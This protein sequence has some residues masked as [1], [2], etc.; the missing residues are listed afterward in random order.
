M[1]EKHKVDLVEGIGPQYKMILNELG[2][3][4][5]E[6]LLYRDFLSLKKMVPKSMKGRLDHFVQ[7]AR[8]IQVTRSG[9]MAEALHSGRVKDLNN[10]RIEDPDGLKVII[11]SA[12]E[13]GLI[14]AEIDKKTALSWIR[15]ATQYYFTGAITGKAVDENGNGLSGATVTWE[16]ERALS[17]EDGSFWL[18]GIPY[19]RHRIY[20]QKEGFKSRTFGAEA[21]RE[22]NSI[23]KIVLEKGPSALQNGNE[24]NGDMLSFG[25]TD[26]LK[27]EEVKLSDLPEGAAVYYSHLYKDGDKKFHTVLRRKEGDFLIIQFV[28][29]K[30]DVIDEEDVIGTAY[31]VVKG[32]LNRSS[33]SVAELRAENILDPV[34]KD[35]Q[36][37]DSLINH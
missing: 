5:C 23:Y 2:I 9:Q 6:D 19:G 16:K 22:L 4:Y 15:K 31:K 13:N 33:K 29:L 28:R 12:R 32:A 27:Q 37:L 35:G 1:Y 25:P 24:K 21:S 17:V 11:D 18:P 34:L 7:Q 30:G 8:L 20:I 36:S 14:K 10:L 3:F 26:Q